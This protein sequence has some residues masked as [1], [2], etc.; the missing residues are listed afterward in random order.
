MLCSITAVHV[1]SNRYRG[2]ITGKETNKEY[3]LQISMLVIIHN[4]YER[5]VREDPNLNLD[6]VQYIHIDRQGR[7]KF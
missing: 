2:R 1:L 6:F 3:P 4:K 7:G 5:W